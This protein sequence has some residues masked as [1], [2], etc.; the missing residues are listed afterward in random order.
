MQVVALLATVATLVACG[1]GPATQDYGTPPASPPAVHSHTACAGHTSNPITLEMYYGSEKQAWLDDVVKTFNSRHY[2][3]CDGP[4]TIHANPIGSGDSAEQIISGA[5][6]PDIRSPAG[7]VWLTLVNDA[8]R[9]KNNGKD[10]VGSGATDALSIVSSPV[11]IAMW[12]PL[13]EA[14]GW[15]K[16]QIA[17]SDIAALSA[18]PKGWGAYG[19]P[20]YGAFKFGHTH[21]DT[22][23]SGL[24]SV[25]AEYYAAVGKTRDLTA[26]DI[27]KSQT[28]DFIGKIE[29]AVIHYGESTGFFANEM[30]NRGP[31]YLHVA[32]HGPSRAPNYWLCEAG[33]LSI[34]GPGAMRPRARSGLPC[35]RLHKR[36]MG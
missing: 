19:H 4:I 7:S 36:K 20:E 9:P 11:V 5:I 15:P 16:K 18:N 25:L 13:A 21:P 29:S 24:D 28:R 1:N 35:V 6:K 26:E 27:S 10:F 23:N 32:P 12:K 2:V 8:W 3:A 33:C 22:S 30:F 34:G 14:L 31:D 17:W